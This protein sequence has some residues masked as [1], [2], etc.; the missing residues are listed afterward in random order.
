MSSATDQVLFQRCVLKFSK[1]PTQ[2][3][4]IC[5]ASPRCEKFAPCL[6]CER[7]SAILFWF[8]ADT[9]G[10]FSSLVL[11]TTC[12]ALGTD[13]CE[14]SSLLLGTARCALAVPFLLC[15]VWRLLAAG[16]GGGI[17]VL[18]GAL[19]FLA[20]TIFDAVVTSLVLRP[21]ESLA[22]CSDSII[23]WL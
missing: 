22:F 4:C 23:H 18:W 17:V 7:C 12:C 1:T 5:I 14:F 10:E 19:Q 13:I 3:P 9:I 21:R 20:G 2:Y 8:G 15:P 11:G 6:N 16:G